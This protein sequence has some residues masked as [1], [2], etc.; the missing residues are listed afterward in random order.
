MLTYKMISRKAAMAANR[1]DLHGNRGDVTLI[2]SRGWNSRKPS[3]LLTESEVIWV[4][5]GAF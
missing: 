5:V 1:G 3:S 2:T 4:A